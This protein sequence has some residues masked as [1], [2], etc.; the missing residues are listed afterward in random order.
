MTNYTPF[1]R[2]IKRRINDD[3]DF[4]T[5]VVGERGTG[6]SSSALSLALAL[7]PKRFSLKNVCFSSEE[8]MQ[9]LNSDKLQEGDVVVWD[10]I[11]A[12]KSNPGARD[13]FSKTNK[14]ISSI[15]QTM[16]Y[17]NLCVLV[18]T[19]SMKYI[20]VHLR[21]LFSGI[22]ETSYINRKE[23]IC[24]VRFLRIEHNPVLDK[25]Y[26]KYLFFKGA[27]GEL[28][29]LKDIEIPK[30]PD[31]LYEAYKL[32][33]AGFTEKLELESQQDILLEQKKRRG[34]FNKPSDVSSIV[35][36]VL[37]QPDKYIKKYGKRKIV[38]ESVIQSD[39]NIGGGL[40][41]RVKGVVESRLE[42]D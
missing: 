16:R 35:E 31:D 8:F 11:G 7:Q 13:W 28:T 42:L 1:I 24:H 9:L 39:F 29:Q 12:G 17:K 36:E 40:S 5:A 23:E 2:Y 25:T 14:A 4:V 20:D 27:D 26:H 15:F 10:E 37:K 19:P 22:I 33:K 18:T 6:K 41:K 3:M 34:E 38:K 30:P 32:K 21:I